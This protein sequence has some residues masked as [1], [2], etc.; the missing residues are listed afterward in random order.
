[1]ATVVEKEEKGNGVRA[2]LI[3]EFFQLMPEQLLFNT[4]PDKVIQYLNENTLRALINLKK[5]TKFL[6]VDYIEDL[7]NTP[8]GVIDAEYELL[9]KVVEVNNKKELIMAREN[10]SIGVFYKGLYTFMV[11][12]DIVTAINFVMEAY[13]GETIYM[14][15]HNVD[16]ELSAH[17][18]NFKEKLEEYGI[19]TDLENVKAKR[20]VFKRKGYKGAVILLDSTNLFNKQSLDKLSQTFLGY[21]PKQ[22]LRTLNIEHDDK[23]YTNLYKTGGVRAIALYN[24]QDVIA[25]YLVI[26]NFTENILKIAQDWGVKLTAKDIKILSRPVTLGQ[27]ASLLIKRKEEQEGYSLI[28]EFKEAEK[29]RRNK[30]NATNNKYRFIYNLLMA[31]Y[32]GGGVIYGDVDFTIT[33]GHLY[34]FVSLYPT[35]GIISAKLLPKSVEDIE[36]VEIKNE[37]QFKEL[38]ER[39]DIVAFLPVKCTYKGQGRSLIPKK[40]NLSERLKKLEEGLITE[41]DL[42]YRVCYPAIVENI[43]PNFYLRLHKEDYEIEPIL[44]PLDSNNRLVACHFPLV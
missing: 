19:I 31:C 28:K 5:V 21:S 3:K 2:D 39:K 37:E 22:V 38:L 33:K 32:Y 23:L 4:N 29:E 18:C 24:A 27:V 11:N 6:F 17:P 1:M 44:N 36:I 16:A 25:T 15:A 35:A 8:F 40:L 7:A 14:Y 41:D 12:T 43:L 9:P 30:N 34:D 20:I 10:I 13:P 26:K 42:T